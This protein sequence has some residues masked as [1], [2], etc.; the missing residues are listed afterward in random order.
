MGSVGRQTPVPA[1]SP[2]SRG[3]DP[4]EVGTEMQTEV[5]TAQLSRDPMWQQCSELVLLG[6]MV[7]VLCGVASSLDPH[8]DLKTPEGSVF[9]VWL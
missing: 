7:Q 2:D 4:T 3:Q 9:P 6:V 8:L 5:G 1:E